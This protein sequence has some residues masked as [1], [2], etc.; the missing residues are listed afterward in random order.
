MAVIFNAAKGRLARFAE[1]PGPYDAIVAVLLSTTDPEP[2]LQKY[3][4]LRELIQAPGSAEAGFIGYGRKIVTGVKVTT[5]DVT[6]T[7]RV[8]ADDV[9]WSPTSASPIVKIVFCYDPD[10][11]SGT[12]VDLIPLFADDFVMTTPTTGT[13]G[14]VVADGGFFVNA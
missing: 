3:E 9:E 6:N 13:I 4:T 14:Y 7:V 10:T 5:D 1:L 2:T 8:D 11:T 12:E